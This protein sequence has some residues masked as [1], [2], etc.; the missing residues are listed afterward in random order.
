MK[1]KV[2]VMGG[3]FNPIHLGHLIMAEAAVENF[4]LD[5]ILFIPN[6]ISYLKDN[7]LDSKTRI[8]MTGIAIEDNP[9]FALSTIEV[10]RGGKSYSYETLDTLTKENPNTE[11]YF[12]IGADS[13]FQIEEW[14]Q[15]EKLFKSCIVIAA[16]RG[17]YT[18][19][20]FDSQIA[21]LQ[22]KYNADIRLLP[23]RVVDISSTNIRE[24]VSENQT[25]RYM[26]HTNV[27]DYIYKYNIYQDS[28]MKE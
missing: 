26:T 24:R 19:E 9:K 28:T 8:T 4:G 27:S 13:I 20:E 23:V 6:G 2:G 15:P 1:K 5:E 3:T 17:G 22:E 10:D 16:N 14:M 7:V 21:L 25:I 12:I 18:T 11:Y